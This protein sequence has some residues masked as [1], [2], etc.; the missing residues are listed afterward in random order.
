MASVDRAALEV[1]FRSTGGESWSTKD[2][3]LTD[4][5]LSTW[6]GVETDE[7]GRVVRLHLQDPSIANY[8]DG[9]L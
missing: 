9:K 5:E 6:D 8:L 2:N 4:A 7:D 3:W 1:L